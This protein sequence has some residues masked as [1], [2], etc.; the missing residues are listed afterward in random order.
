MAVPRVWEKIE[1]K[2]AAIGAQTTGLKR[3]IADWAKAKSIEGTY[4][5]INGGPAPSLWG[6]SKKLV[7][8]K[9]KENLG[10]DQCELFA[11]SAAPMKDSTRQ[12]F[13]NLNIYLKNI[14]GMSEMAGP[15]TGTDPAV[16]QDFKGKDILKEAGTVLPGATI[17]IHNPDAEGNG[18]ICMRGRNK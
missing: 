18:E 14:Y 10:L 3:Q 8:N 13:L 6:L 7:F 15:H 1:E 12:F 9:I 5:D 2:I 17:S 11:F 4:S 16:F